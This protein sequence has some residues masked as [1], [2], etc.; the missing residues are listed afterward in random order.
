MS[1]LEN[2][3]G[4]YTLRVGVAERVLAP[5]LTP[6]A[7]P[8]PFPQASGGPPGFMNMLRNA[9]A[10]DKLV[11]SL[12]PIPSG[13]SYAA[14]EQQ[15]AG[16]IAAALEWLPF[17]RQ[18]AES[19]RPLAIAEYD[20]L[21]KLSLQKGGGPGWD[22][23]PDGYVRR[24]IPTHLPSLQAFMH[25]LFEG[26]DNPIAYIPGPVA[27]HTNQGG[28]AFVPGSSPVSDVTMILHKL[29]ADECGSAEAYARAYERVSA[30]TGGPREPCG[31][32]LSRTGPLAKPVPVYVR[33]ASGL[34][35]LG[36]AQGY[37]CRRRIVVGEPMTTYFLMDDFYRFVM[38][39]LLASRFTVATLSL[40]TIED[41]VAAALSSVTSA[42]PERQYMEGNDGILN[43][44]I[45]AFDESVPAELQQS[46]ADELASRARGNPKLLTSINNWLAAE[47]M[48]V[49]GPAWDTAHDYVLYPSDGMT[50]SGLRPT[51]AMGTIINGYRCTYCATQAL[52]MTPSQAAAWVLRSGEVRGLGDDTLII[53]PRRVNRDRWEA[54]SLEVGFTS[55]LLPGATFLRRYFTTAGSTPL[56]GRFLQQTPYNES[57]PRTEAL[58]ALGGLTRL[59][60]TGPEN[61]Y[62][63][64]SWDIVRAA[65][66]DTYLTRFAHPSAALTLLTDRA[67]IDVVLA[68]AV[69]GDNPFF[70]AKLAASVEPSSPAGRAFAWLLR[71]LGRNFDGTVDLAGI[72]VAAPKGAVERELA[73]IAVTERLSSYVAPSWLTEAVGLLTSATHPSTPPASDRP[74]ARQIKLLGQ[75]AS[76]G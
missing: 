73:R 16:I 36:E 40:E 35:H 2:A 38:T 34:I 58:E 65:N 48:P 6:V 30:H 45:S 47:R 27:R 76:H 28:P 23:R 32:T 9:A 50:H 71:A 19:G 64:T 68:D 41:Q 59:S 75:G 37:F 60:H 51:A 74:A 72:R 39:Y 21:K 10:S 17:M 31:M 14:S 42:S 18:Q 54:A 5:V 63:Q 22:V 12:R 49:A 46:I 69:A 25:E 66:P 1:M 24:G 67:F 3:L 8:S 52:D 13:T 33:S 53:T 4:A 57:S 55:K 61:P 29:W 44:D 26:A 62:L 7:V 11:P 15:H 20:N 56:A 70:L 43:D